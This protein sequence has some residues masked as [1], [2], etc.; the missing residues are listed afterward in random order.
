MTSLDSGVIV[1][2]YIL[3]TNARLIL[4]FPQIITKEYHYVHK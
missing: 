4:R 3:L 1:V 2:L